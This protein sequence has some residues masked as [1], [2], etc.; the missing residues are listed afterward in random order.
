MGKEALVKLR[1]SCV[2]TGSCWF[3]SSPLFKKTERKSIIVD[4]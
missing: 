3:D 1:V 4:H 2:S